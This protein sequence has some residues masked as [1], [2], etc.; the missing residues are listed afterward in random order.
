MSWWETDMDLAVSESMFACLCC[1][2]FNLA[3]WWRSEMKS[4]CLASLS[5]RAPLYI[6]FLDVHASLVLL[7]LT[8]PSQGPLP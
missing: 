7:A 5:I 4:F 8:H 1:C 3:I 2:P 6:K